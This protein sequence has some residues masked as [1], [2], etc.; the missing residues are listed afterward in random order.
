MQGQRKAGASAYRGRDS[1]PRLAHRPIAEG[2]DFCD[3]AYALDAVPCAAA[4]WSG[5]VEP[6][7]LRSD[8]QV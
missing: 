7:V 5:V 4:S 3:P 6:P 8:D 2:A 1:A